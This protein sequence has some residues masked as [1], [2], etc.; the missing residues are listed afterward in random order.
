MMLGTRLAVVL[1][2]LVAPFVYSSQVSLFCLMYG[3]RSSV[4]IC[5]IFTMS[6]RKK[7]CIS[8]R[9]SGCVCED[10]GKALCP[11]CGAGMTLAK[12]KVYGQ[13]TREP[14]FYCMECNPWFNTKEDQVCEDGG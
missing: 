1:K 4:V 9:Q 14:R 13:K 8:H 7:S 11:E 6:Q 10:C 12:L 5:K 2:R 3:S